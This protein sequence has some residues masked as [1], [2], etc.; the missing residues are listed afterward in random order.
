MP[1][2]IDPKPQHTPNPTTRIISSEEQRE[3]ASNIR[4]FRE[5]MTTVGTTHIPATTYTN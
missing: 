4:G 5:V 3:K 1:K 2:A